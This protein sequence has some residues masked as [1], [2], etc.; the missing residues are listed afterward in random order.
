MSD[1]APGTPR[2]SRRIRGL[3][4]TEKEGDPAQQ[5][6]EV[7]GAAAGGAAPAGATE[8]EVQVPPEQQAEHVNDQPEDQEEVNDEHD[9]EDADQNRESGDMPGEDDH[10]RRKARAIQDEENISRKVK[11]RKEFLENKMGSAEDSMKDFDRSDTE[12][13]RAT[14]LRMAKMHLEDAKRRYKEVTADRTAWEDAIFNSELGTDAEKTKLEEVEKLQFEVSKNYVNRT[15]V[16]EEKIKKAE[17][18]TI[19]PKLFKLP[20]VTPRKFAGKIVDYRGWKS[21]FQVIIGNSESLAPSHKLQH[22]KNALE[23]EA[24][25][26]IQGLGIEDAD[27][28]KAWEILDNRYGDVET[29]RAKLF[30]ELMEDKGPGDFKPLSQRK[31]HDRIRSKYEKL[32]QIDPDLE[33]QDSAI[34]SMI[35]KHYSFSLRKEL[36]AK[37][38]EKPPMKTFLEEA[39]KI[40]QRDIRLKDPTGSSQDNSGNRGGNGGGGQQGGGKKKPNNSNSGGNNNSGS[41]MGAFVG[42]AAA[43]AG[44][45]TGGKKTSGGGGGGAQAGASG[46]AKPKKKNPPSDGAGGSTGGATQK[47]KCAYCEQQGHF[48]AGCDS[49]KKLTVA[50]REEALRERKLCFRCTRSG[51][52]GKECQ[53]AKPCNVD[54]DSG[55]KCGRFSHHRLIHKTPQN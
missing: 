36:A 10:A 31:A 19:D 42:G 3:P 46:G 39:E 54:L 48:I 11:K 4:P 18:P 8:E 13:D 44:S 7:G 12:A 27:Y 24:L 17:G 37:L 49:F 47:P 38:G 21:N 35:V 33:K 40:I 30:Q 50:Q 29:L 1:K 45:G 51:H 6:E 16:L 53:W 15:A 55:E 41:T 2:E 9:V 32:L 26:A 28:D 20:P 34:R 5:Q 25:N 22:L 14:A 43:G 52:R 23:G